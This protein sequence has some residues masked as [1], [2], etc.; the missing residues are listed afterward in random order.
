M[1]ELLKL[2]RKVLQTLEWKIPRSPEPL[3]R[4]MAYTWV[5]SMLD[6]ESICYSPYLILECIEVLNEPTHEKPPPDAKCMAWIR[7]KILG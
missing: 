7:C 5:A 1:H 2:E 3:T 4:E 6:L